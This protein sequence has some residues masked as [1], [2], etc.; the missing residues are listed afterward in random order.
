MEKWRKHNFPN[1]DASLKLNLLMEEVGELAKAYCKGTAKIKGTPEYWEQQEKDAVGDVILTL[2]TY[3]N[4]RGINAQDCVD[5]A[6]KEISLRD[7]QK[8]PATGKAINQPESGQS[9]SIEV[10]NIIRHARSLV[11]GFDLQ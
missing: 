7:Y 11:E 9:V 3:C 2:L 4:L 5:I 6:W 1:E 10:E 8:Y